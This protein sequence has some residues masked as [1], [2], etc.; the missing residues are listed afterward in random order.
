LRRAVEAL[1]LIISV[2]ALAL[3][4]YALFEIDENKPF[5]CTKCGCLVD[6]TLVD[7]HELTSHS[8]SKS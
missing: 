5:T 2:G 4:I 8:S 6:P 3:A 7:Y 1:I